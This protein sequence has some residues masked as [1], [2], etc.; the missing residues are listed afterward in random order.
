METT[1]YATVLPLPL[2]ITQKHSSNRDDILKIMINQPPA[3]AG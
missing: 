1:A 2:R 3:K